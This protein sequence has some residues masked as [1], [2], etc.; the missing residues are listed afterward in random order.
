M[1]EEMHI[2]TCDIEEWFHFPD[3]PK[4]SNDVQLLNAIPS[5]PERGVKQLLNFCHKSGFQGTFC[6]HGWA[7]E[8]AKSAFKAR[9]TLD[10]IGLTRT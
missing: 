2:L 5:C 4:K 9:T 7:P 10:P 6:L 1:I 3:N 8:A